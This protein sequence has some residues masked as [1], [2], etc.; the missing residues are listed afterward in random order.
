MNFYVEMM[1]LFY[2]DQILSHIL[3]DA[4]FLKL[5]AKTQVSLHAKSLN[6]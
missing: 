3:M 4:V 5:S 6:L 1:L 2:V